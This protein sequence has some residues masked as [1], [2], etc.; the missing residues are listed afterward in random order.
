[1]TEQR[2]EKPNPPYVSGKAL[3]R[4][5][6]LF[7]SRSLSHVGVEKLVTR[8]FSRTDAYQGL[9]ALRFLGLVDEEGNTTEDAKKLRM[10]GDQRKTVLQGIVKSS[11]Q[12]LF[13]TVAEPYRL[14]KDELHNEFMATYGLSGRLAGSAVRAFL[15]ISA[16][17][18]FIAT[19][20]QRKPLS[21]NKA[22]HPARLR[23][24]T[25][26]EYQQDQPVAGFNEFKLGSGA[27]LLIPKTFDITQMVFSEKF[28]EAISTLRNELSKAVAEASGSNNDKH[29]G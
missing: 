24:G 6:N 17:A 5:L 3:K 13:S 2:T 27:K 16:E 11:Y 7:S 1:M 14:P 26:Q 25:Q 18:G 19:P 12:E 22:Q 29:K 4:L 28:K 21:R 8:D 23:E 9:Q 10:R 15:L 20:E